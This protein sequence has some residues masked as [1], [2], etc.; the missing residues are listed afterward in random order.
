KRFANFCDKHK[1]VINYHPEWERFYSIKLG[2]KAASEKNQ[3]FIHNVD[4][5]FVNHEVLLS[6]ME[7]I[8]EFD[9]AVPQYMGRGGHP[10]LLS[11]KVVKSI[12]AEKE[13]SLN[14][15]NYLRTYNK[16]VVPVIDEKIWVNVNSKEDYNMLFPKEGFFF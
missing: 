15:K 2:L 4:N 5:P 9:Y 3:V 1:V 13:N 10:V 11:K 14:L 16:V 7:N 12:I 8:S 6:L